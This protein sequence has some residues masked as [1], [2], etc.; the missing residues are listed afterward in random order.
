VADGVVARSERGFVIL[1]LDGD[2]DETTGWTIVYLHLAT[3][4]RMPAGIRVR[5]GD[6]LG[7]ASCEGGVSTATHLHIARR[8]NGEWIPATCHHC[9]PGV[10]SV[11]FV[12]GGWTVEGWEGQEYQG[13]MVKGETYRQAEQGRD[14]PINEIRW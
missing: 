6:P 8:Y 9:A 3:E 10:P 2:G 5:A 13:S 4:G 14:T 12:L 11:P 1:D 7:H